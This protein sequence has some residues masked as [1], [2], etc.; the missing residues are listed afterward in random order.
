MF[1]GTVTR[2][3]VG[4]LSECLCKHKANENGKKQAFQW[5][6]GANEGMIPQDQ[7]NNS[8]SDT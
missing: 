4:I 5:E 6:C 3:R 7:K 2:L 8:I 1:P